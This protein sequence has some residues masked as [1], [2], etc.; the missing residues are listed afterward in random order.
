MPVAHVP[1]AAVG[2]AGGQVRQIGLRVS[3][4]AVANVTLDPGTTPPRSPGHPWATCE[5]N[6]CDLA[7]E[8]RNTR[9]VIPLNQEES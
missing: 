7:C 8:P 6:R 9:K 1:P 3:Y 5:P 4:H 2:T